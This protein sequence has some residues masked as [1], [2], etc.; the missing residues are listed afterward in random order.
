MQ[1]SNRELEM[2]REYAGDKLKLFEQYPMAPIIKNLAVHESPQTGYCVNI[3][4]AKTTNNW[5]IYLDSNNEITDAVSNQFNQEVVNGWRKCSSGSFSELHDCLRYLE[6]IVTN[7]ANNKNAV[8][9]EQDNIISSDAKPKIS[10]YYLEHD[11]E[12][13]KIHF[14]VESIHE[15][16]V[17]ILVSDYQGKLV[18]KLGIQQVN[19][20]SNS[21]LEKEI[22]FDWDLQSGAGE[23]ITEGIYFSTIR[24]N[25][26]ESETEITATI[27]IQIWRKNES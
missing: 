15:A 21:H 24:I 16:I 6:D 4:L 12:I 7:N 14:M 23:N 17:S 13:V 26:R 10:S 8:D 18:R 20:H 1:L 5:E 3:M 25:T 11:Q 9:I 27:P 19:C 22:I 2:L